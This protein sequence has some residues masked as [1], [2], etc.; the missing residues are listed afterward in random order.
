MTAQ[1]APKAISCLAKTNDEQFLAVGEAGRVAAHRQAGHQPRILIYDMAEYKLVA[2][3]NGHKYGVLNVQFS[4]VSV[5]F[6][7]DGF[8][9]LWDWRAGTKLGRAKFSAKLH[10]VSF[11]AS[12]RILVT[13]GEKHLKFWDL[14][15]LATSLNDTSETLPISLEGRPGVLGEHK[16][17]VIVDV[18]CGSAVVEGVST[19]H[20]YAVTS[21]GLVLMFNELGVL[22]K[23]LHTKMERGSCIFVSESFLICGGSGGKIRVFETVTLRH[24]GNL[25][26]PEPILQYPSSSNV[27]HDPPLLFPQVIALQLVAGSHL[28]AVY[29]NMNLV[30]Y[31]AP[32]WK[33]VTV[34]RNIKFHADCIWG[35][36]PYTGSPGRP[37]ESERDGFVT[38]SSDGSVRFWDCGQKSDSQLM[39]PLLADPSGALKFQYFN[40]FG[41]S[42]DI[43]SVTER[44]GIRALAIDPSNRIIAC[45]DRKGAIGIFKL[46]TF[47]KVATIDAHDAEIMVL[48]FALLVTSG[49]SN[50]LVLASASRDRLI[51]VF[52][53]SSR[54][55]SYP[56]ELIQTLDDHSS[57]LTAMMFSDSGSKLV[58][59]GADKA[60]V[61]RT[62]QDVSAATFNRQ[63]LALQF[64]SYRNTPLRSTVY[65]MCLAQVART[66]IT[67]SQDRR[68]TVLD[69]DSG[70]PVR[71]FAASIQPM[72]ASIRATPFL[73]TLTTDP[74]GSII[75]A[76]ASDKSIHIIDSL[77]GNSILQGVGH[78]DLVT[79]ISFISNGAKIASTSADGCI[80]VWRVPENITKKMGYLPRIVAAPASSRTEMVPPSPAASVSV[81]SY[82]ETHLPGWAKSSAQTQEETAIPSAQGRW[83]EPAV[84]KPS[85]QRK[86]SYESDIQQGVGIPIGDTTAESLSEI[87]I[88]LSTNL[89]PSAIES[90][91]KL[92]D[93]P[94]ADSIETDSEDGL[95]DLYPHS[96]SL[97]SQSS[98]TVRQDGLDASESPDPLVQPVHEGT[99]VSSSPLPYASTSMS[100]PVDLS[101][102]SSPV[103]RSSLAST[104]KTPVQTPAN[105]PHNVQ[106]EPLLEG[107]RIVPAA[108]AEPRTET[109]QM[110]SESDGLV[111]DTELAL[112]ARL[113]QKAAASVRTK[114]QGVR[115]Y[116]A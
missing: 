33:N 76:G 109:D 101:R 50:A 48:E 78:G 61:F 99:S 95:E 112:L 104:P 2:T 62:L 64:A 66:I 17:E 12:D 58:S 111:V 36:K 8:I 97:D 25:P 32:N 4:H 75:C 110:H 113:A 77:N 49:P 74:T 31:R 29:S 93:N 108:L 34:H 83:A 10:S 63:E 52:D 79:D 103:G 70:K 69:I 47:E 7:H 105:A 38:Y 23:W 24:L 15:K 89:E 82:D 42:N 72:D 30:V 88:H 18:Q 100:T 115:R 1:A 51:H 11:D 44:T 90:A 16:N 27:E 102:R 43:K 3:L 94:F 71:S 73:N 87:S 39:A 54:D 5:G 19:R 20:T 13:A 65:D 80:F 53:A 81:F 6:N 92:T 116:I 46:D 40:K 21:S 41:S 26:H 60:I 9:Y 56:F 106:E 96:L 22:E 68:L 107:F 55:N 28:A 114:T 67:A 98:F 85:V 37:L 84:A 86:Y 35:V 45:G 14:G 57:T 91:E 59:C